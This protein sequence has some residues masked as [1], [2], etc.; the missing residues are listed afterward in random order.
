MSKVVGMRL[1]DVVIQ[2]LDA[3]AE[4]YG[5]SRSAVVAYCVSVEWW[6]FSGQGVRPD[7]QESRIPGPEPVE[8]V[9]P[10]GGEP[11]D[12]EPVGGEPVDGEP[13]DG[14]PVEVVEFGWV[15]GG[16]V[17]QLMHK[18]KKKKRKR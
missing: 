4:A 16:T 14:E 9:E 12:G 18:R 11:V 15:D 17:G 10:V 13:V 7:A 1:P 6:R 3:L 8:P 5:M 2:R